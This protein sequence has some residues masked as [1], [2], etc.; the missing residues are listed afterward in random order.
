MRREARAPSTRASD[1]S[2]IS[3]FLRFCQARGVQPSDFTNDLAGANLLCTFAMWRLATIKFSSLASSWASLDAWFVECTGS[4]LP[5]RSHPAFTSFL[6]GATRLYGGDLRTTARPL[7]V[8]E[9]ILL[10]RSLARKGDARSLALRFTIIASFW[11]A[12][13]TNEACALRASEVTPHRLGIMITVLSSK[14]EV[15]QRRTWCSP[16][17]EAWRDICPF[18]AWAG[19]PS[20]YGPDDRVASYTSTSGLDSA[21]RRAAERAGLDMNHLTFYSLRRGLVTLLLAQGVPH[22]L[23]QRQ[24]RW[25]S[26]K[27]VLHYFDSTEE[28]GCLATLLAAQS[29]D[30][31]F[32]HPQAAAARNLALGLAR[33][34]LR[35]AS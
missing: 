18:T 4:P 8:E 24:G 5:A 3:M 32:D 27:S 13:R 14:A 33:S 29:V 9:L 12:L 19:F 34:D 20:G 11:A 23:V 26:P 22:V 28:E 15:E 7:R 21:F 6:K 25:A 31:T 1:A 30:P 2:H 17:P 16:C 10:S 35:H